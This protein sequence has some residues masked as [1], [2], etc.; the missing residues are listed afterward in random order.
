M[1]SKM[2]QEIW[3]RAFLAALPACLASSQDGDGCAVAHAAHVADMAV[4]RRRSCAR[5][6]KGWKWLGARAAERRSS[7]W[8]STGGATHAIC[9]L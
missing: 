5:E 4:E 2:E 3:D 8:T 9:Q 7:G 1:N 6:R